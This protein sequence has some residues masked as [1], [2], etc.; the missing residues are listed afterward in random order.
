MS[1]PEQRRAQLAHGIMATPLHQ[2]C[3]LELLSSDEGRSE[4]RF[5]VNDFS[6][7]VIGTLHGGITYAMID[8][9][10]FMALASVMPEGQ[11]GV[12]VDIQVSVLRAA[13]VGDA[14]HVRGRVDRVGRTLANMRAEAFVKTPEGERLIATGTVV[15]ALIPAPF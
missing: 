8:V 10:S 2:A 13:N 4:I 1:I 3:G 15:K 14:V 6:H 9:A 12:T 7:N 11:H 5:A